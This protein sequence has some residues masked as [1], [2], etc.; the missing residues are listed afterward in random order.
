MQIISTENRCVKLFTCL[1]HWHTT[2]VPLTFPLIN[3]FFT[4]SLNHFVIY[5]RKY[6]FHILVS[7]MPPVR[8]P[9]ITEYLF[10]SQYAVAPDKKFNDKI[11]NNGWQSPFYILYSNYSNRY[12]YCFWESLLF[13]RKEDSPWQL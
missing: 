1:F 8:Y 4:S 10:H 13:T 9:V 11:L 2:T 7:Q 12:C 3:L 5:C 6:S